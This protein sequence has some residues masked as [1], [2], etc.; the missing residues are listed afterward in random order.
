MDDKLVELRLFTRNSRLLKAIKS[1]D[2]TVPEA[3]K[4]AGLPVDRFRNILNLH[5][6]PS[7]ED[8]VKISIYT[9]VPADELFPTHLL[10][11][12][13]LGAF[14]K[15]KRV[16]EITESQVMTL[17]AAEARG[18][19]T[20]GS[21]V[22]EDIDTSLL[23]DVLEKEL[24]RLP[25]REQRVL[26]L[27]FGLDDNIPRTL[28]EVGAVMERKGGGMGVTRDRARQIEARALRKLRHQKGIR[29]LQGYIE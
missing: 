15:N 9:G 18:L 14:H 7:E 4:E 13:K 16:K 23:H 10:E 26:R 8:I 27:R 12:V 22:E 21:S 20:D 5:R 24:N 1:A 29:L 19:I 25:P 11:A 3:A 6:T 17:S 2:K 28:E